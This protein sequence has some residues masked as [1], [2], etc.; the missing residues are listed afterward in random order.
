MFNTQPAELDR[1]FDAV[2]EALHHIS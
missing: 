1:L 2:G